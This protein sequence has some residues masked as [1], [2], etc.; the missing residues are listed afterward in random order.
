MKAFLDAVCIA[1]KSGMRNVLQ[2]HGK[3]PLKALAGPYASI[4]F[5]PTGGVNLDNLSEYLSLKN[6]AAVGGSFV[7][8]PKMVKAEDYEGISAA[9]KDILKKVKD[10][11]S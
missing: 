2:K 11:R 7:P 9:C 8:D 6:V 10:I 5:V 1:S 4:K 3:I